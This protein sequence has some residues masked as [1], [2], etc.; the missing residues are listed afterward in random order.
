MTPARS[1]AL[2]LFGVTGDLAYKKIFPALHAMAK[3]GHLDLPVIGVARPGVTREQLVARARESVEKHGG[4]DAAAFT[5]L[6]TRLQF[7]GGD[8]GE[9]AT[10]QRL[11]AALGSAQHPL[12]YLAIPPAMFATVAEGLGRSGC[13]QGARIVVEKPFGRDLESAQA[14]NATLHQVFDE[15]DIFRIDHFLGKEPVQNLL[16]FR[17]ANS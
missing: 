16:V 13:A 5:C 9:A 7:V 14:L 3:R 6:E 12:H 15:A 2:V 4:L 10:Y 8:Y 17:F 11:R 1:D